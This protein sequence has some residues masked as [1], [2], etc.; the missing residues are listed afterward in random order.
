MLPNYGLGWGSSQDAVWTSGGKSH[1]AHIQTLGS[2]IYGTSLPPPLPPSKSPLGLTVNSSNRKLAREIGKYSLQSLSPK[3]TEQNIE[4]WSQAHRQE[5]MKHSCASNTC[6]QS[7]TLTW[8]NNL[9]L[10][11][12]MYQSF[13]Q[14]KTLSPSPQKHY[15]VPTVLYPS[16]ILVNSFSTSLIISP[17]LPWPRGKIRKLTIDSKTSKK[18]LN[19]K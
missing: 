3:V 18:W 8:D 17:A 19:N 14:M 1:P 5:G 12:K 16:Q 13:L 7:S 15:T 9:L 10:L 6:T 4:E 2:Q 11:Y